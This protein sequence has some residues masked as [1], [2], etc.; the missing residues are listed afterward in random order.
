MGDRSRRTCRF[1]YATEDGAAAPDHP[2]RRPLPRRRR[3]PALHHGQGQGAQPDRTGQALPDVC[4]GTVRADR[5]VHGAVLRSRQDAASSRGLG[6]ADH[7]QLVHEARV[8]HEADRGLPAD[9]GP[10]ARRRH[11]GRLHSRP[12]HADGDPRRPQP[13]RPIGPTVRAVLGIRGEPGR[14]TIRRRAWSGQRS[15]S[16]S[17][18]PAGTTTGSPSPTSIAAAC[19]HT[20]G[21]SAAAERSIL[22]HALEAA[23]ARTSAI[24]DCDR[25]RRRHWR[26]RCL[27]AAR[28]DVRRRV[29]CRADL[30]RPL[31]S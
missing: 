12:R 27:F 18:S 21:A 29:A 7:L 8:R 15:S 4:K 6:R 10:A 9:Q 1:T 24:V 3:Q 30:L 17:T 20:H 28:L 5:A 31:V 25:L 19:Q 26:R 14:P 11:L 2:G 13:A 22:T 16:M 23:A